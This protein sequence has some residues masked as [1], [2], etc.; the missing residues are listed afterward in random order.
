M[1]DMFSFDYWDVNNMD[2]GFID[3][4]HEHVI[5]YHEL[6]MIIFQFYV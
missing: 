5:F 3:G 2:D 1:L 4:V 6:R